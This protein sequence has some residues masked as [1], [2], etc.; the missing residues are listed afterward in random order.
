MSSNLSASAVEALSGATYSPSTMEAEEAARKQAAA[1]VAHW[2]QVG[3]CS[4]LD[5]V[6]AAGT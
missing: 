5:Q 2:A 1:L 6:G 3:N 4:C